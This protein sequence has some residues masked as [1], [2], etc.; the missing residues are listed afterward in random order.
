MNDRAKNS[1]PP[2][3]KKSVDIDPPILKRNDSKKTF[4]YLSFSLLVITIFVLAYIMINKNKESTNIDDATFLNNLDDESK[5][6]NLI[7]YTEKDFSQSATNEKFSNSQMK[8]KNE[9]MI[10]ETLPDNRIYEFYEVSE[11]PEFPG[12]AVAMQAYIAKRISYPEVALD[13]NIEGTVTLLLV[14]DKDG[15]ISD[16][17]IVKDP[18]G[19]LGRE[20]VRVIKSMPKWKPGRQGSLPVSVKMMIPVRFRSESKNLRENLR[21]IDDGSVIVNEVIID[22]SDN[23]D[24]IDRSPPPPPLP[25]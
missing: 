8:S 5:S 9:A 19:G 16:V 23:T 4:I 1:P 25:Y 11:Q 24:D 3:R 18:G 22:W 12:G 7:E 14:I 10:L 13:N 15:S 2:L 17:K 20:A 6:E 21:N